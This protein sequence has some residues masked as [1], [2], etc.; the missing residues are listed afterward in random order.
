VHSQIT[1]HLANYKIVLDQNDFYLMNNRWNIAADNYFEF[2]N[3][4]FLIHHFFINNAVSQIN[5]ASV[6]D[7]FN[8]DLNITVKNFKLDDISRIIEKDTSLVKGNMDG[9]I[10]FKR[11]NNTYGI[12]AD[13]KISDLF[14]H[15]IPVGNFS[16]KADNPTAGKFNIDVNLSG[17]DNN[18]AV[19][20]YFIPKGGDNSIDIKTAI[21]SLSMKTVEAFSMKQISETSGTLSGNLLIQGRPNAPDITGELVFNDAFLKPAVL[22]NRVELK[23]ETLQFNIRGIYFKSFT[24]LDADQQSAII[25]GTVQMKQFKDFVFNLNVSAKDFLLFNTTVKDNKKFY[26]RMVID[27]KIKVNGPM[28]LPVISGT[29]VMKKGSNFTFIVPDDKLTT[30]KGEDVI[31]FEGSVKLNPI[32]YRTEKEAVLKPKLTGFDLSTIIEIDKLATLRLLMDPTSTDSLVVRGEGALSFTMDRSGR[33][34]LTGAYNLDEG[35][36]LVTLRSVVK[37]KF[38]IISGSTIIWYG[39]PMDAEISINAKYTV[40]AVPYDLVAVQM[41]SLSNVEKGGY[42]Q[43]YPFWVLLKLRGEIL[44]PV[45]SF[46][47]QLPPE[48]KGILGGAV[49]QKLNM[50]NDDPSELNKQVFAL[51]VLGRFVQ[52][53]PLQTESGGTSSLVRS[54]VGSLL[55][56]QLNKLSSKVVPGAELNFDV[57][58]YNDYQTGVAKGRTQVEIGLKKQLFHERLSVQVGGSVDVEGERAKQNSASDIAGDVTVEYKLTEDGRYRLSAFRHNQYEGEI[59]GQ[60]IESGAGIVYVRDFD[61][62]N[63]FLKSPKGKSDVLKKSLG[64]ETINTK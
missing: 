14:I 47:I 56:A 57:Q 64:N 63:E 58:S 12:I 28:T 18:L 51:L 35:S 29:L 44:H 20:G 59:E 39:D 26:G 1:K 23:H 17:P 19:N 45:I 40:R 62:W 52:E 36:Y 27:S 37:R 50:L 30:D 24:I 48:D 53:N 15:N 8:D 21:K 4:G 32:L 13:A 61:K 25:D 49:N 38:D 10:L 54:T 41:S 43:P 46:E 16:V 6:N 7:K 31:E 5:I 55:S 34:S 11:V 3:E 42:K 22:N 33:M 9:N 60:L 2:G